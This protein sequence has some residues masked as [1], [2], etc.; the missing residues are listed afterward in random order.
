MERKMI[1][2]VEK[3]EDIRKQL[4]GILQKNCANL[5]IWE[6][7]HAAEGIRYINAL[8]PD[9]LLI[10]VHIPGSDAFT[11]LDTVEHLPK[12]VL[13]AEDPAAAARAF[14]YEAI[15]FL[16]QPLAEH[17]VMEAWQKFLQASQHGVPQKDIS[18][19]FG[20]Y[21]DHLLVERGQ[22]MVR[23]TTQ[24]ITHLKA[25]K[26]YTWIYTKEGNAYLS[27]Y[28]IGQ[29]HR[30]LNPN[31][32]MRVHRSYMVNMD[33]VLEVYRDISKLYILLPGKVEISVGRNYV[34]ALKEIMV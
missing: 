33:Y 6:S 14:E 10:N 34:A 21:S 3:D 15:D 29:L 17:R 9:L 19:Y 30:K 5:A 23:L 16:L 31:Q 7:A 27:S 1:L 13:M 4:M 18:C 32:F 22:R 12:I 26:D 28:G 11:L 25:D 24:Q 20:K 8:Q 2:I